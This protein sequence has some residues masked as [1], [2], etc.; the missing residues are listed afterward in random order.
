MFR[1]VAEKVTLENKTKQ[2]GKRRLKQTHHFTEKV[3][4]NN[5]H[6]AD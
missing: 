5:M 4:M 1:L 3:M 2:N 6:D